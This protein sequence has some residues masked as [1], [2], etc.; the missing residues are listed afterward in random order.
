MAT[1]FDQYPQFRALE[2]RKLFIS[3]KL[4]TYLILWNDE[5]D[6]GTDTIYELGTT[7]RKSQVPANVELANAVYSARVRA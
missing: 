3:G 1:L 7:V 4:Y 2:D 5:L 6:I